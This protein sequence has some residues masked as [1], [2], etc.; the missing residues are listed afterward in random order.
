MRGTGIYHPLFATHPRNGIESSMTDEI[1]ISK[2]TGVRSKWVPGSN[3]GDFDSDAYEVI[4]EGMGR[5]QPNLDWRARDRNFAS[6]LTGTTTIRVQVPVHGNRL[7]D[8]GTIPL[9]AKD[10]LVELINTPDEENGWL[11]G[12]PIIVRNAT[13]ATQKWLRTMIADT[14]TRSTDG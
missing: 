11:K 4:Y 2:P 3:G 5:V 12:T 14:G 1:R 6:E 13:Q 9:I 7:T 8:D 10:Y